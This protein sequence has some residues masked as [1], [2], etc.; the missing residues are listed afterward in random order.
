LHRLLTGYPTDRLLV[1]HSDANAQILDPDNFLEGVRYQK[2]HYA[3]AL[4]KVL[5]SRYFPLWRPIEQAMAEHLTDSII[6]GMKHFQPEVILTVVDNLLW[7]PASIAAQQL[8]IPFHLIFHDDHPSKY[9]GNSPR[10]WHRLSR[11]LLRRGVRRAYRRAASRFCVS[12]G[13]AETYEKIYG[14]PAT[15]L[16][17]SRG[18]DSPVPLVRVRSDRPPGPPAVAFAGALYTE[19]ARD[20]LRRMAKILADLG[21]QLHLFTRDDHKLFGLDLPAVRVVDFL[22]P[23]VMA[24]K[25]GATVDVLFLPASYLPNEKRDVSTLFPSKLV[26]YTAV[27]LPVLIWGPEYSSAV[28]WGKENPTGAIT[29]TNPDASEIPAVLKRLSCNADYAS[30]IAEQGIAAGN[31]DFSLDRGRAQLHRG[32]V[33]HV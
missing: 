11:W 13:M 17:P 16:Y 1:V 8:G 9:T 22:P 5:R 18:E 20:L 19:G 4:P 15:V 25:M 30:S 6:V 28:R 23:K 14:R 27:G 24:E 2:I 31:R 21:G 26:D 33:G 3:P 10:F 29:V 12:P 7:V 32:L